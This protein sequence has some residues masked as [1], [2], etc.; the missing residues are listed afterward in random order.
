MGKLSL[1][2]LNKAS[3]PPSSLSSPAAGGGENGGV[4]A[5][6]PGASPNKQNILSHP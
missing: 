1:K 6:D 3:P 2:Q 4:R 5:D